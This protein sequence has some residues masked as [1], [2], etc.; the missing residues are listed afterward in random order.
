MPMKRRFFIELWKALPGVEHK[1]KRSI[2]ERSCAMSDQ[3]LQNSSTNAKDRATKQHL[4]LA[5]LM[6]AT[7]RDLLHSGI[8]RESAL[9]A[10]GQALLKPNSWVIKTAT[11]AMLTVAKDPM[12]QLVD[13]TKLNI[14]KKYGTGFEFSMEGSDEVEFTMRVTKCFYN[15]YFNENSAP[16]LTSLFC[17]WDQNWIEPISPKRHKILFARDTTIA[18]GGASCPFTFRRTQRPE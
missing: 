18:E 4:E 6:L 5:A 17:A 8:D 9:S 12:V 10:L 3:L 14:L 2:E 7:Y 1:L 11:K 15:D 16:E 13:Y